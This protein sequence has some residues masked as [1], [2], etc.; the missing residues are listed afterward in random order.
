M[1][2]CQNCIDMRANN[3]INVTIKQIFKE[4]STNLT[5]NLQTG[6]EYN[7]LESL[8]SWLIMLAACSLFSR[9]FK[10]FRLHL[11]GLTDTVR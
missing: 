3:L 1:M 7:L 6:Q 4:K 9:H 2:D 11:S 10:C 5:Q 8:D